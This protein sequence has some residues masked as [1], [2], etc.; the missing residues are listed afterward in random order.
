MTSELPPY[1]LRLSRNAWE[2][3]EYLAY[4][5]IEVRQ[6]VGIYKFC[7]IVLIP[8]IPERSISAG[9]RSKR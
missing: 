1:L 2:R 4:R 9:S 5:G 8:K 7:T 6:Y 3:L